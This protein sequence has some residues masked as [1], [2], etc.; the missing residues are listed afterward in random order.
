MMRSL[1]TILAAV[2]AAT[3]WA[4]PGH[5]YVEAP[6]LAEQV[7]AGTLPP[8][9][10]RLPETPLVVDLAGQPDKAPGRYGG[11]LRTLM[12]RAKD[13][14]MLVVYGYARLVGYDADW[15]LKA[16][17]LE[18]YEVE[19]GRIFTFHLRK[20]HKWSDGEPFTSEDFRYYW[21]D[22]LNNEEMSPGGLPRFL[23][24]DGEGPTF[25]VID[26]TTVRYTWAK[27]NREFLPMLAGAR[28][29]YM[30]QPA[31]YLKQ[32]HAKYTDPKTLKARVA[33]ADQRNWVALHF[34]KSHQ[35]KN[36]D[37]DLPTLQPWMLVTR[38]PASRFEFK[39]NPYYYR[40]DSNGL[41]LPYIDTVAF[42]VVNSKLIP[43]KTAAGDSDLQARG[44]GFENYAIL[45]QGE[46]HHHYKVLL[47]TSA[48]GAEMALYPNLN[49]NDP[50]WRKVMRDVRVRR[51]LSL[52]ID[53][54]EINQTIYFGLADEGGNTVLKDSPLY[55]AK[56]A[57]A[58]T[59]FDL[60]QADK[61]LDEAG[62]DKRDDR[63]I[64][65]LP[66][67]QPFE[68]IVETAGEDPTETDVLQLVRDTWRKIGVKLHI[69]PLQREVW[70]NRI[71]AG[72]TVMSIWKGLE[73]GVPVPSMAPHEL[74]PTQQMQYEWPKWGQYRETHGQAG[75]PVDMEP[76]AELSKA[77]EAWE[78]A[79]D[80][81][82]R[83]GIWRKM[84]DI[85]A[86]NVFTIGIVRAVPQPVVVSNRLHNVPKTAIYNWEPGA[87]F[88]I[89]RPD[90]FWFSDDGGK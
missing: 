26:E 69:K 25:E 58:W 14:R 68:I 75:E 53:R 63:G 65:L 16:D 47:W 24:V 44:L 8:V 72:S 23:L 40:V 51:A 42:T 11:T 45:K 30:Y 17:I 67:G 82:A 81:E 61:L 71:F 56:R 21:E 52:A 35:Y 10:Q 20:G 12:G 88:G 87:H 31:H 19:D 37:P 62:L 7:K 2:L 64:R 76:A 78:A 36:D 34:K 41:Q 28:P 84:L 55:D 46:Q 27:P 22:V 33:E 4:A 43:A 85:Y 74:A 5:A 29:E 60:K 83:A 1:L 86:D 89:H 90:Q 80:D 73:N 77:Y 38:P 6:A 59:Q 49:T 15:T 66:D 57:K 48:A 18:S 13:T 70:R 50:V 9:D 32:F 3:V 39:R 79:T 54:H